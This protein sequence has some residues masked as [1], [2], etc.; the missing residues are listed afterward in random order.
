MSRPIQNAKN[1]RANTKA[2][3][4]RRSLTIHGRPVAACGNETPFW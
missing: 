1:W 3:K 4:A 2:P